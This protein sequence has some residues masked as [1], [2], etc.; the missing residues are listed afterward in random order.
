MPYTLKQLKE[1]RDSCI[2]KI[3]E[4]KAQVEDKRPE[5]YGNLN[6]NAIGFFQELFESPSE[7]ID[8]FLSFFPRFPEILECARKA[9]NEEK[10]RRSFEEQISKLRMEKGMKIKRLFDDEVKEERKTRKRLRMLTG[11]S[12]TG[13]SPDFS[14][15][16]R[17]P[18][19]HSNHR[20]SVSNNRQALFS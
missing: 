20:R 8:S 16:R 1:R 10:R 7:K 15:R 11:G 17:R 3:Q 2:K 4:L 13:Q 5:D 19:L 6:F 18:N 9:A 12:I 14:A